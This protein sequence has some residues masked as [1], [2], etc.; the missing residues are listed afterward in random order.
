MD[1]PAGASGSL[2]GTDAPAR[3]PLTARPGR[4]AGAS[5]RGLGRLA[6]RPTRPQDRYHP[7]NPVDPEGKSGGVDLRSPNPG[8]DPDWWVL[9]PPIGGNSVVRM[10]RGIPRELGRATV[11]DSAAPGRGGRGRASGNHPRPTRD[12]AAPS[13]HPSRAGSGSGGVRPPGPRT[14]WSHRPEAGVESGAP[15]RLGVGVRRV[16][17]EGLRGPDRWQPFEN[18]PLTTTRWL[19]PQTCPCPQSRAS[20]HKVGAMMA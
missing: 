11:P 1:S 15:A 10:D 6:D 16:R 13:C 18:L 2:A 17:L 14:G 12:P 20:A 8:Y 4:R 9:A 7:H 5:G 3:D 19:C